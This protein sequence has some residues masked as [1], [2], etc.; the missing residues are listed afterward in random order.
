METQ[1]L[2]A[3]PG[4]AM[5]PWENF[6]PFMDNTTTPPPSLPCEI[7][8]SPIS[9]KISTSPHPRV[10]PLSPPS[11]PRC[12]HHR[13]HRSLQL[14]AVQWLWPCT[15][16]GWW[17]R[18]SPSEQ[19]YHPSGSGGTWSAAAGSPT[20]KTF[21]QL[22]FSREPTIQPARVCNKSGEGSGIFQKRMGIFPPPRSSLL[23][24]PHMKGLIKGLKCWR[25]PSYHRRH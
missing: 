7:S 1:A 17:E 24:Q 18:P 23:K 5:W 8:W 13:P 12:L 25:R 6:L 21:N 3:L 16:F 2:L 15:F 4:L 20:K 9:L 14:S 11:P 10:A 19:P 22:R